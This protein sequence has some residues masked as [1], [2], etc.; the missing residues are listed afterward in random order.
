MNSLTDFLTENVNNAI[1][2]Q[3]QFDE[4]YENQLTRLAKYRE[5]IQEMDPILTAA[6][7]PKRMH[8]AE[9]ELSS[10]I[11]VGYSKETK[12]SIGIRT[13]PLRFHTLYGRKEEEQSHIR[14]EIRQIPVNVQEILACWALNIFHINKTKIHHVRSSKCI[15]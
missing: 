9:F 6:L 11:Q 3:Q 15:S 4:T 7:A 2:V 8:V 10:E 13:T 5:Q 14:I 1:Q 12:F